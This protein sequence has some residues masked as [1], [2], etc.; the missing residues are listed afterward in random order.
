MIIAGKRAV[1]YAGAAHSDG[2]FYP[3]IVIE[4]AAGHQTT[5]WDWGTDRAIFEQLVTQY[6]ATHGY[7][8]EEAD[9]VVA[10]SMRAQAR[11]DKERPLRAELY[12]KAQRQLRSAANAV[13]KLHDSGSRAQAKDDLEN[14]AATIDTASKYLGAAHAEE[15]QRYCFE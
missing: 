10:S 2:H 9:A 11:E 8:R 4:D 5:D 12:A 3:S 6:N 14:A 7:S 1:L 13:K 15:M